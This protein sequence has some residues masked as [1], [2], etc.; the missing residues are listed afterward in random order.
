[1]TNPPPSYTTSRD[2]RPMSDAV[3]E[4]GSERARPVSRRLT[5][6]PRLQHRAAL[7]KAGQLLQAMG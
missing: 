5:P 7:N 6:R 1:M 2:T 4:L 3:E